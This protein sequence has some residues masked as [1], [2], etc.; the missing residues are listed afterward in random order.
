MIH[1]V[2]TSAVES[3]YEQTVTLDGS[4]YSLRFAWCE[5]ERRWY[6][7]LDTASGTRLRSG[8]KVVAARDLFERL[9]DDNRPPGRLYCVDRDGTGLDPD[10][11]DLGSRVVLYY[12]D[13]ADLA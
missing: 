4:D 13:E 8:I 1:T 6:M 11:R 7:D 2:L 10:L 12:I 9:T 5:R 3:W